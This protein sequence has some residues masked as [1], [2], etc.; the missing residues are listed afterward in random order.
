LTCDEGRATGSATWLRLMIA[1][2]CAFL[3]Y[4]VDIWSAITHRS[5]AV[6]AQIPEADVIAPN[7]QDVWFFFFREDVCGDRE[8]SETKTE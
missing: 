1:E 3:S 2:H 4:A 8:D 5:V 7:D 6:N